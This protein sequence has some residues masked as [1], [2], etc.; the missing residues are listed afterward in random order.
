MFP[1]GPAWLFCP[2]DRPDRFP[3]ALARAD[4]LILDLEDAVSDARKGAARAALLSL[5]ID[6]DRVVVRINAR[7][8]GHQADDLAVL[9][10]TTVQ[11][12]MVPKAERPND[13]EHLD[14][15]ELVPLC[16]TAGGVLNAAQLA[17]MPGVWGLMWG[18]E[19]L[20]STMG[21][22][23]SR[24]TIGKYYDFARYARS[25]VLLAARAAKVHA[26]DSVHIDLEDTEGLQT[27]AIQG[28]DS[29]FSGKACI[30]PGQVE[31]VRAAYRPK[32]HLVAW[33]R[34][35]LEAG[36]GGGAAR[37]GSQMIDGPLIL[38]A[39]HILAAALRP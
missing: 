15:Y 9:R 33:A 37:V 32:P 12:I 20:V 2:G 21:G 27:E 8:S 35:V 17:A 29:G 14:E 39:E 1:Y 7:D 10:R 31:F 30:H 24:D 16:E 6:P 25:H 34:E 23:R 19:D 26:L 28:A 3:K 38:Q 13:L 11:R 36:R 5:D 4:V 22:T 18:A